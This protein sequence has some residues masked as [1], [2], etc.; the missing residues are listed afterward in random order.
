MARHGCQEPKLRRYLS[1]LVLPPTRSHQ[2]EHRQ[3]SWLDACQSRGTET[4]P[5]GHGSDPATALDQLAGC[6]EQPRPQHEAARSVPSSCDPR[7]TC[8]LCLS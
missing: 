3:Y 8:D 6:D 1:V 5:T 4:M 7:V 2:H